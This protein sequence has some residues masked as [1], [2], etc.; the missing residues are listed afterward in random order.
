MPTRAILR[1]ILRAFRDGSHTLDERFALVHDV[2]SVTV[3][4]GRPSPLMVDGDL[5][6]HVQRATFRHRPAA[7]RVLADLEV[8]AGRSHEDP[9]A[10]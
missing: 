6:D 8:P 3:T 1:A 5:V 2:P 10:A 4:T 7:L 9:R